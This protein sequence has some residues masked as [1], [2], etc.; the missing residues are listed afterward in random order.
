MNNTKPVKET[1]RFGFMH[2]GM[3]VCCAVMLLPIGAFLLAG[4]TVSGLF[5]NLGV[6]APIVLCI[7]IHIAMF[8]ILGKS[9]HGKTYK[10]QTKPANNADFEDVIPEATQ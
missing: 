1:S 5:S 10:Q 7:G 8:A 3:A 2:M 6:F 4:G 9:C